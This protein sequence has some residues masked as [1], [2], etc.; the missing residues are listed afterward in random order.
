MAA[1]GN[2][3]PNRVSL[4]EPIHGSAPKYAGKD[5]ANPIGAILTAAMMLEY[6]G[7]ASEAARIEAAVTRA[8]AANET[9]TDIGGSLG[10]IAAGDAILGH[11][12]SM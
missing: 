8:I 3:H 11:L 5:H 6:L 12:K 1:S 10:T 9:T 2:I 7:Y 4:F